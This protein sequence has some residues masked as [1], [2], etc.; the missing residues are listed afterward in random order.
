MK[1]EVKIELILKCIEKD[2]KAQ[3]E[4]YQ[5]LLP[6]MM[7]ICRR[8]LWNRSDTQDVLQESF[9]SLFKNLNQYDIN[10]ASF[11]TWFSRITINSCLAFNK[12]NS[13]NASTELIVNLHE[14]SIDP[15]DI[16]SMTDMEII[17]YLEKMPYPYFQVFNLFFLDD[18]S[19]QEIAEMLDIK[20]SLSRKRLARAKEWLS[21]TIKDKNEFCKNYIFKQ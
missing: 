21:N 18:F 12:R 9:I 15:N 17:K 3:K 20:V 8:Y 14:P 5:K 13:K 11:K 2:P 19:H 6:S 1:G 10:K 16:D 7:A 4:L